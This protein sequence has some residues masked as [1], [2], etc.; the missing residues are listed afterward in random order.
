MNIRFHVG[1]EGFVP[2]LIMSRPQDELELYQCRAARVRR[3]QRGKAFRVRLAIAG[4]V[5]PGFVAMAIPID[6]WGNPICRC[7]AEL[8]NRFD[9]VEVVVERRMM[10]YCALME[11]GE[12]LVR[13]LVVPDRRHRDAET[14]GQE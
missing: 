1:A 3:L 5:A 2:Q 6:G 11:R 12:R 13:I 14:E 10:R 7:A 4:K 9:E 8:N